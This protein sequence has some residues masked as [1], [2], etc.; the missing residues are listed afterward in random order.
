MPATFTSTTVTGTTVST[1]GSASTATATSTT[2]GTFP[3]SNTTVPSSTGTTSSVFTSVP[4]TSTTS[5]PTTASTTSCLVIPRGEYC[6][7]YLMFS[8]VATIGQDTFGLSVAP[9]VNVKNVGYTLEDC[10]DFKPDY[11]NPAMVALAQTLG[12]PPQE[13][14]STLSISYEPSDD[15]FSVNVSGLGSLDLSKQQC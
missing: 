5:G 11:S 14:A 1:T 7:K 3:S 8:G 12:I 9:L 10:T 6:G 15:T 2:D 13:L 4:V